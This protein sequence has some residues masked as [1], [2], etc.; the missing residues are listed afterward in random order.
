M[1]LE[2]PCVWGAGNWDKCG[3][4]SECVSSLSD[5]DIAKLVSVVK[6]SGLGAKGMCLS[7]DDF[8]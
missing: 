5:E 4:V 2:G 3:C 6:W 7:K 1:V 8:P